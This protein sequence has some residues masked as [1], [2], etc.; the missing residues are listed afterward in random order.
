MYLFS[1]SGQP[2]F[3]VGIQRYMV[4]IAVLAVHKICCTQLIKYL[5]H[6]RLFV[7]YSKFKS[8]S[9]DY[10]NFREPKTTKKIEKFV[11]SVNRSCM[12]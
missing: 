1:R 4:Y 11:I 10:E 8:R 3:C 7:E 12:Q 5:K 2:Q 9:P 6:N